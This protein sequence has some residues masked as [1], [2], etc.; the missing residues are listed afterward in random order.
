MTVRE[1]PD[2]LQEFLRAEAAANRRSMNKQVIVTLNKYRARRLAELPPKL[3]AQKKLARTREI[4]KEI[5]A[6]PVLD[7]RSADEVLGHDPW[8]LPT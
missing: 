7:A 2:D 3:T 6:L 4:Q 5:A 1:I 8:G